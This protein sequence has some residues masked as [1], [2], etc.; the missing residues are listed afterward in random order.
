MDEI[1]MI[2]QAIPSPTRMP[3]GPVARGDSMGRKPARHRLCR[4]ST[5]TTDP[6]RDVRIAREAAFALDM[7]RD[8]VRSSC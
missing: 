1:M 7:V 2:S 3:V 5:R 6:S 8:M 4:K